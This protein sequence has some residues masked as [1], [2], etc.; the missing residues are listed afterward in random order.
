[1]IVI[2]VILDVA[3]ASVIYRYVGLL[4]YILII[5]LIVDFIVDL[6][7]KNKKKEDKIGFNI[8]RIVYMLVAMVISY[9]ILSKILNITTIYDI[10]KIHFLDAKELNINEKVSEIK[11]DIEDKYGIEV[12]CNTDLLNTINDTQFTASLSLKDEEIER[13]IIMLNDELAKYS[14]NGLRIIPKKIMLSKSINKVT[15]KSTIVLGINVS[16]RILFYDF[17][18]YSVDSDEATIHHE[19]FHSIASTLSLGTVQTFV[20]NNDLCRLTTEY[21][22]TNT[23]EHLAEAWSKSVA[24]NK[25]NKLI[26]VLK[27]YY[28]DYLVGF[29]E[30][31][32]NLS[33]EEIAASLS[34]MI[35]GEDNHLTVNKLDKEDI[36]YIESELVKLCPEIILANV[37]DVISSNDK[38]VFYI[39][40]S[41]YNNLINELSVINEEIIE[42]SDIFSEYEDLD[43]LK[44]I[45]LY[46]ESMDNNDIPEI[47]LKQSS[48]LYYNSHSDNNYEEGKNLYLNFLLRNN[49]F[50]P[51]FE[52]LKTE[53]N[54]S[55]YINTL[56]IGENKYALYP[57]AYNLLSASGYGFL[58]SSDQIQRIANRNDVDFSILQCNDDSLSTYKNVELVANEYDE[59]Q[60]KQHLIS[61][62][63]N[64]IENKIIVYYY[65]NH[66]DVF[67]TYQ[68]LFNKDGNNISNFTRIYW[69]NIG[70]VSPSCRVITRKNYVLIYDFSLY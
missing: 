66:E 30:T 27:E 29:S 18:V 42:L 56:L 31:P 21:A 63:K 38:T 19:F 1:M 70:R 68:Y 13:F 44:Q 40:R 52:R 36:D 20:D 33:N 49:G 62:L 8:I 55:T 60:I 65:D 2:G 34:K 28:D 24:N 26:G 54:G 48:C 9:F 12:Y 57:N 35:K 32:N 11:H 16:P 41:T 17:I 53:D 45:Y 23:S 10:L 61:T 64:G 39:N 37:I 51:M 69:D 59:R 6:F 47:F 46:V 58:L 67:K 50:Y 14:K 22:C 4:I 5:L 3:I 15:D 25:D 7:K 43:K